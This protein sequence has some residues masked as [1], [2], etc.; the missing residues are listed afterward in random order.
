MSNHRVGLFFSNLFS[1]IISFLIAYL[2]RFG[3][4]PSDVAFRHLKDST[5]FLYLLLS[6]LIVFTFYRYN[7]ITAKRGILRH[8]KAAFLT[9]I[10]MAIIFS[11]L[12]YTTHIS[13]SIPRLFFGTFFSIN[14]SI[15]F[16]CL[17]LIH[18]IKRQYLE[19]HTKKTIII[20]DNSSLEKAVYD[21]QKLNSEDCEIIGI[22]SLSG[23]QADRFYKVKILS[24]S[25]KTHPSKDTDSSSKNPALE[26]IKLK[27]LSLSTLEYV[28]RHQVDLVIFSVNHLARKK[29]EH[30]IEAFSEMG[31]DSL[32]TID[33][34]AIETLETKLEDF[35][36]TN[37]IRLSPR[38]FT[39]GE[40]LLK[41]LMDIAGALVGCFICILFGIIVA[42]LIFLED[43]GPIIFKQK[44]VGRNGK[45]FY[46]YKFRSMYQDA[47]AKLQTLKDQ[48]EMQGFMFKMKNDPRITKIGKILRKTSIDELPQFFNVL[49][50]SMSLIGTRP[51]TVDEYNQYSAHHKRRISI[52]PGITG[53]W[54]VS[55]R[56]EITDFEEIVRLDCFY[57]DHWSI[58]GD[59]KILLKT[60]AA[61]FTG[62]GSE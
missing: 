15:S 31:I 51:P 6:F 58:T 38:L 61:V 3:W 48:N 33:S 37:V 59:I 54:Q 5:V 34:F 14:F 40:L 60:F 30:L 12:V 32:I 10:F 29:N 39:D 52:K 43:P 41:R 16:S 27:E 21:I 36:T 47:E 56:S 9:N 20:T 49:E 50:G 44:R 57:I 24:S 1:I 42:P 19:H 23:K 25:L 18:L 53:L 17:F 62:K 13:D 45:F 26:S 7:P 4:D 28:K 55:G 2:S 8:I 46:I 35:G 22:T 11:T